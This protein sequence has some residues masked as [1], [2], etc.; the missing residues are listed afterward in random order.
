VRYQTE[1]WWL[2]ADM[3]KVGT[4][5]ENAARS[6]RTSGSSTFAYSLKGDLFGYAGLEFL[7][8]SQQML[9]IR[10]T[11]KLGLGYYLFRTTSWYLGVGAGMAESLEKYGGDEPLTTNNLEGLVGLDLNIYDLGDLDFSGKVTLYPR[12]TV[13]GVRMNSDLSIKYDLPLEFYIK[14]SYTS[15]FDSAPAVNVSKSDFVVQTSIGWEW[16]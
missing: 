4:Y 8:N 2:A 7:R 11:S 9:D 15:N 10:A 1:R 6:S 13:K 14:L 12:L 16:D 3:N 5:Q